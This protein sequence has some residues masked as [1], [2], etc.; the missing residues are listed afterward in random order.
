MR[1]LKTSRIVKMWPHVNSH[2]VMTS[3]NLL[4]PHLLSALACSYIPLAYLL[5][6]THETNLSPW[7]LA[8]LRAP[9]IE[10]TGQSGV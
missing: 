4:S 9:R 7:T 3:P 1:V 8:S 10:D 5:D 6:S 2:K